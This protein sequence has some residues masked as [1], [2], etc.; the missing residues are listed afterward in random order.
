MLSFK[1]VHLVCIERIGLKLLER[2]VFY[3]WIDRMI[4]QFIISHLSNN[5]FLIRC[6]GC[7]IICC[8]T[9]SRRVRRSMCARWRRLWSVWWSASSSSSERCSCSCFAFWLRRLR[10]LAS[11]LRKRRS[12]DDDRRSLIDRGAAPVCCSRCCRLSAADEHVDGWVLLFDGLV[13]LL[14][15]V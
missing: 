7:D 1:Q 8:M 4:D 6:Q 3:C 10:R 5:S 9:C 2:R 15:L 13:A 11:L 14:V 12:S